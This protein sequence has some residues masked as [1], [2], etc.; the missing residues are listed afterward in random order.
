[1]VHT[2]PKKWIWIFIFGI[3]F[4]ALVPFALMYLW[5]WLM[6]ELFNLAIINYWQAL[7]L[8]VLSKIL[9]SG[10]RHG[11]PHSDK[12]DHHHPFSAHFKERMKARV[13]E[14]KASETGNGT[15][16]E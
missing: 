14:K 3:L 12:T 2:R 11:A 8:L 7:G 1:M 10:F 5:N 15:S 6:P 16:G 13:E 9:F 4:I